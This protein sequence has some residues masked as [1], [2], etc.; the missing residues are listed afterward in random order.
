MRDRLKPALIEASTQ[1]S[2][3]LT[4]DASQTMRQ[5]LTELYSKEGATRQ[6]VLEGMPEPAAL[7][8]KDTQN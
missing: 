2:A 5:A 1:D 4:R 3:G 6:V 7:L 8:P